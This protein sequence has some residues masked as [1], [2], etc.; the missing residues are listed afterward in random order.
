MQV[1]EWKGVP[2]T[3]CLTHRIMS[4][5]LISLFLTVII[6][7]SS[8][9]SLWARVYYKCSSLCRGHVT[10]RLRVSCR[11]V[12]LQP[13]QG[14]RVSCATLQ[15]W[16]SRTQWPSHWI[17]IFQVEPRHVILKS[18]QDEFS[19]TGMAKQWRA[20]FFLFLFV[21]LLWFYFGLILDSHKRY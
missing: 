8:G 14:M 18:F 19:K 4:V 1:F 15:C 10:G 12:A 3:I 17:G 16:A 5:L 21:V 11:Q 13:P 20:M 9:S 7:S 2:F 6:K